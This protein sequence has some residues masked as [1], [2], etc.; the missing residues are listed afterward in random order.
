MFAVGDRVVHPLHG[1]GVIEAVAQRSCSGSRQLY[2]SLH[3]LPEHAMIY[4]PVACSG[5]IGLRPLCSKAE[6]MRI[7]EGDIGGL[8]PQPSNWN[9]RY[10]EN[11]NRIASGRLQAVA[12][13]TASL[14]LKNQKRALTGSEKRLL[15]SAEHILFSELML[16]TGL[17][18][19]EIRRRLTLVWQ[20][21]REKK[22]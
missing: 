11:R 10:R 19:E 2:Y 7:L 17:E 4:V 3:L 12:Q 21:L 13:V 6:A 16:A 1:A 20:R 22:G 8:P 5:R 18:Y 14:W 9:Q 15:E